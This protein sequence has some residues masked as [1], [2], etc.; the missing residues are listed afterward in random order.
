[1]NILRPPYFSFNNKYSYDYGIYIKKK[2]TYN[3]PSRDIVFQ[4]IPGRDGDIIIDNGRY[5]NLDLSYDIAIIS[6]DWLN[7]INSI[8]NWLIPETSYYKIFDS[9]DPNYYRLGAYSSN[10]NIEQQLKQLGATSLKFNCKPFRYSFL[11]EKTITLTE[12]QHIYNNEKYYS[13]PYIKI[14]GNGTIHFYING[15]AFYFY[16]VSGYIEI[17]SEIMN[18]HKGITN[19]NNKMQSKEFPKL[20]SGDNYISWGSSDGEVNQVEIKPNWR[21]L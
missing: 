10:T 12:P 16:D 21:T 20:Q 3:A 11:G 15:T 2:N 6:N 4:S 17:D 19:L 9:Y 13:L 14:Y 18:C 8:K 5:N 1:M 7:N